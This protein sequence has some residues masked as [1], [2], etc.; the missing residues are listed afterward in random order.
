[1][2]DSHLEILRESTLV[3][4]PNLG[5]AILYGNMSN[6]FFFYLSLFIFPRNVDIYIYYLNIRLKKELYFAL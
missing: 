6:F 4:F 2:A 1:M 3:R 5:A